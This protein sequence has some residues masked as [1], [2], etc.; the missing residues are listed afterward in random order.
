MLKRLRKP[1]MRRGAGEMLSFVITLFLMLYI[2][3]LLTGL[4]I[5]FAVSIQMEHIATEIARDIVVCSSL[6][7]AQE[8]AQQ[9]A[10]V[11]ERDMMFVK[12]N[13][14]SADVDYVY[15][16]EQEWAKGNYIQLTIHA[17][18]KST[19]PMTRGWKSIDNII[20]IEHGEGDL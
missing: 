18:V 2:L 17:Y 3:L 19:E 9:E 14:V 11:M 5:T 7:E 1:N 15:A 8:Q 6:D 16:S 10:R 12:V 20:M 4:C 13:S